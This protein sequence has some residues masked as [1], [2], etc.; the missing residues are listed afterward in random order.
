MATDKNGI[1]IGLKA[2]GADAAAKEVAKVEEAITDAAEASEKAADSASGKGGGGGGLVPAWEAAGEAAETAAEQIDEAAE[3]SDGMSEASAR[4]RKMLD[5]MRAGAEQAEDGVGNLSDVQEKAAAVTG[6]LSGGVKGLGGRLLAMA[7][8]PVGIAVGAIAGLIGFYRNLKRQID[9]VVESQEAF[10][11]SNRETSDRL[12]E[13]ATPVGEATEALKRHE[14]AMDLIVKKGQVAVASIDKRTSAIEAQRQAAADLR[15][16]ILDLAVAERRMTKE[17]RA[18]QGGANEAADIASAADAALAEAKA[19]E[20]EVSRS[21][22]SALAEVTAAQV[23]LIEIE[24]RAKRSQAEADAA[25]HAHRSQAA[26]KDTEISATNR[27]RRSLVESIGEAGLVGGVIDSFV[28]QKILRDKMKRLQAERDKLDAAAKKIIADEEEN[29]KKRGPDLDAAKDALKKAKESLDAIREMQ[30]SVGA[31]LVEADRRKKLAEQYQIPTVQVRTKSELADLEADRK[32]K[33]AAAEAK[34]RKEEERRQKEEAKRIRDERMEAIQRDIKAAADPY[35]DRADRVEAGGLDAAAK[36]I[37]S[38]A[39]GFANGASVGELETVLFN[40][41]S[42]VR[43][44]PGHMQSAVRAA[45]DPLQ[46]AAEEFK[47]RLETLES[48]FKNRPD[49]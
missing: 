18:E 21:M 7:G 44:A 28:E 19:K 49:R 3:V 16:A 38:A 1:E 48:Q 6:A 47:R 13:M 39:R 36:A 31:E 35:A 34:A 2:T 8:G 5:E 11:A 15:D 45:V 20:A 27:D 42:V 33:E 30:R 26:R 14:E 46:R 40:L 37:D 9:D 24:A 43:E 17:E 25:A 22:Q 4:V 32:A 12:A 23:D 29:A 10:R 41:E